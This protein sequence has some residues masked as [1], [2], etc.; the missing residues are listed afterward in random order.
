MNIKKSQLE[1]VIKQVA[2]EAIQ[3]REYEQVLNEVSPS[4][5]K[6][7]RIIQ[8]VKKSLRDTHPDWNDDKIV[9]VAIATAWKHHNKENIDEV[10]EPSN[11]SKPSNVEVIVRLLI[12]KGIKDP[13]K[14]KQLASQLHLKQFKKPI[15]LATVDQVIQKETGTDGEED[16]K[17]HP[18][19][20]MENVDE[21]NYKVQK[22]SYKTVNDNPN[23]PKNLADPEIPVTETAYKKQGRSYKTFK[24]SPKGD[25]N[26]KDDPE[27][28]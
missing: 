23:D 9:S 21:A 4:G 14:I 19:E 24:D 18:G 17:M 15:D 13:E 8:H 16:P 22:R 25:T 7:E 28:T 12:D 20:D 1:E 10:G 6:S 2:R 27:N 11:N 5:K 3:Q 26:Y